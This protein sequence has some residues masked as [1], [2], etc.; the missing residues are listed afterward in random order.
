M[1]GA[2]ASKTS[3]FEQ[4]HYMKVHSRGGQLLDE[5]RKDKSWE[6][7][8]ILSKLR[9]GWSGNQGRGFRMGLGKADPAWPTSSLSVRGCP[10][11]PTS[12]LSERGWLGLCMGKRLWLLFAWTLGNPLMLSLPQHSPGGTVC[13]WLAQVHCF[14]KLWMAEPN[15]STGVKSSWQPVQWCSPGL[16]IWA[17]RI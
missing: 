6:S 2:A 7:W 10:A 8:E 12:S 16:R 4:W 3:F 1:F 13:S 17:S 14:R 5:E 9:S 11:W 15:Q